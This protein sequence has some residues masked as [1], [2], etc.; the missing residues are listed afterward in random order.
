[1]VANRLGGE[2]ARLGGDVRVEVGGLDCGE[3]EMAEARAQVHAQGE[4]V[5]DER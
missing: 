4:P 3:L 5:V 1:M 2:L